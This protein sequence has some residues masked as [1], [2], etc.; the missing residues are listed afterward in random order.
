MVEKRSPL[1]ASVRKAFSALRFIASASEP[2]T[3]KTL[4]ENMSTP[5]P[6]TYHLLNTL[7]TEGVLVKNRSLGYRLGPTIGLLSDAYLEQGEPVDILEEPL[8]ELAMATGE[9]AYLS[10][11]RNGEIEVVATAEGSHAVRVMELQ[12]GSYGHAHAR[13]SGKL[14]LAYARPGL[15]DR[16][17]QEHPRE[18]LTPRTI[19][20]LPELQHDFDLIRERGYSTDLEEFSDDV[21]C[22]AVPIL[23]EDRIFAAYTVSSP[24]SRFA[25]SKEQL[26]KAAFDAAH[27]AE[28]L[29]QSD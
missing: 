2:V 5:L 4:A 29:L 14:L 12:R 22:V 19:T 27:T 15:R 16:Y 26:V 23:L 6:T 1:I 21:S 17:L 8:K 28:K 10:A 25:R 11:W 9:S 18:A 7:V 20:A 3:A 13:A 24:S